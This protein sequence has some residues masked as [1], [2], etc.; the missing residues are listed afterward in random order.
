MCSSVGQHVPS[1][2]KALGFISGMKKRGREGEREGGRKGGREGG[3]E[4]GIMQT[5]RLAD[6]KRNSIMKK[7]DLILIKE[8]EK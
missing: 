8:K 2:C 5:N 1:M 4:G 7:T 3:K 6:S